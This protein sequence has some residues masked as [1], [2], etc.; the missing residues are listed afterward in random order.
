M[1]KCSV[2]IDQNPLRSSPKSVNIY[3]LTL[4]DRTETYLD[5]MEASSAASALGVD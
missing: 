3:S 5:D 1:N 2:L 4:R